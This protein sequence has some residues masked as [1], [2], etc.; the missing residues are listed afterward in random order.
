MLECQNLPTLFFTGWKLHMRCDDPENKCPCETG[1]TYAL[2]VNKDFQS[3][4]ARINWCPAYF[5]LPS[6]SFV[7]AQGLDHQPPEIAQNL[8]NYCWNKGKHISSASF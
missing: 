3:N 7:V 5:K 4:L 6:L 8:E 1:T 2:T